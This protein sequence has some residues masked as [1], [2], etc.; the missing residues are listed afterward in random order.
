MSLYDDLGGAAAVTAALNQFY[1]K[2]LADP[3]TSPYFEGVDIEG[4][5]KRIEPFMAMALGGPSDYH[6]PTLRQTHTHLGPGRQRV[7]RIPGTF[8]GRAKGTRRASREDRGSH[9]DL[10]RS[11]KRRSESLT[12]LLPGGELHDHP[13]GY[14][15]GGW[16][17]AF[18]NHY[19][20][21][22]NRS[23]QRFAQV[24]PPASD[25]RVSCVGI[26][27]AHPP[28][29][30]SSTTTTWSQGDRGLTARGASDRR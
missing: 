19:A 17:E 12:D 21:R 16:R 24:Y 3:L 5:K 27:K 6:G 23:V 8:R 11:T 29:D 30:R 2:V 15:R 7:R 9:A 1:P 13:C 28:R 26:G 22:F 20:G 18:A 4:L 25:S 10:S 14:G